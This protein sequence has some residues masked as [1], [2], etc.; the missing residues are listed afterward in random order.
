[1][2]GGRGTEKD[3]H[4]NKVKQSDRHGERK[5]DRH[6]DIDRKRKMDDKETSTTTLTKVQ[7][8]QTKHLLN[9]ALEFIATIAGLIQQDKQ[10]RQQGG[11]AEGLG[12]RGVGGREEGSSRGKRSL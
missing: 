9:N 3:T 6:T 11:T 8:H 5:T 7:H 4:K 1:M 10:P 2:Q 12:T